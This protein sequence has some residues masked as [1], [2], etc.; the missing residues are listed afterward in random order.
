MSEIVFSRVILEKYNRILTLLVIILVGLNL[1][2]VFWLMSKSSQAPLIVFSKN[3]QLEVLKSNNLKMD[4]AFIRDFTRM[5]VGQYL[6]FSGSSLPKQIEDIKPY[7]APKPTETILNAFK[8]NQ[9]VIAKEGISQ[10][11]I[12]NQITL[13]KKTNPFWVEVE[14]VRNIHANGNDKSIPITYI[15]EIRKI[16]STEDN[17][18]GFLMTDIIEKDQIK[19]QKK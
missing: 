6:S 12:I 16:K 1:I 11:F 13:S 14:G 19:G 10:Q 7:L 8:S 5:I 2:L 18:Y 3:G 4:E 15:F 17:P 9:A